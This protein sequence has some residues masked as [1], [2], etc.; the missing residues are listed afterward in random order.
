M[1]GLTGPGWRLL[2]ESFIT[3]QVLAN[4]VHLY[5]EALRSHDMNK[6]LQR[7]QPFPI[8]TAWTYACMGLRPSHPLR[9]A[10]IRCTRQAPLIRQTCKIVSPDFEIAGGV[11]ICPETYSLPWPANVFTLLAKC[12]RKWSRLLC[13]HSYSHFP[14]LDRLMSIRV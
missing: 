12:S 7:F 10:A 9:I 14:Y 11:A 13:T 8:F 4:H 6:P 1:W 5:V 3:T 2:K